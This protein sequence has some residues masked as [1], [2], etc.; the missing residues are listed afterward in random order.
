MILEKIT[1]IIPAY[2]SSQYLNDALESVV[3]QRLPDYEIIVVDDGST[4]SENKR[5]K[6]ILANYDHAKL[7]TKKN[8]G[9]ASARTLGQKMQLESILL[10]L[11]Q[12][13]FGWRIKSI[14]NYK[15]LKMIMTSVL[16]LEILLLQ[17]IS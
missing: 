8:G 6:E 11:I 9:A 12:M 5:L 15:F 17:M 14:R 10:F 7:A 2:N 3:N 1:I 16:S 4:E 13:I